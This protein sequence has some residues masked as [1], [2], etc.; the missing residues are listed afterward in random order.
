MFAIKNTLKIPTRLILLGALSCV[1]YAQAQ[2][3]QEKPEIPAS[4][5]VER[6]GEESIEEWEMDLRLPKAAPA[7]TEDAAYPV[8]PDD[9]QNRKLKQLLSSL[10]A[11]PADKGV[12]AQLD[13]QLSDILGQVNTLLDEGATDKAEPLVAVIQSIDPGLAGFNAVKKRLNSRQEINELL[14]AGDT[15]LAAGRVLEPADDSAVFFYNQAL[16]KD[17]QS[18]PA[19]TGLESVQRQLIEHALEYAREL[20]FETADTWLMKASKVLNNEQPVEDARLEVTEFKRERA[21]ELQQNVIDAMNAGNFELAHF[22]II[23]LM[24]LGGQESLVQ[25]LMAR[26]EEARFYGGFEPGQIISDELK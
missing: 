18:I 6:L 24:A 13:K 21:D 16:E 17:P 14:R 5:Q 11:N 15:A 8:L 20:D 10:A 9:E 12:R 1:S 25:A 4:P 23:D 2:Q 19:L 26:L 7:A 22:G 3:S